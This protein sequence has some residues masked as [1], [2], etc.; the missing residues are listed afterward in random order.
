MLSSAKLQMSDFKY[1]KNAINKKVKVPIQSLKEFRKWP[2]HYIQ[3]QLSSSVN[4]NLDTHLLTVNF[5]SPG[6]KLLV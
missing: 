6:R 5:L 3:N 2:N 1:K 4:F